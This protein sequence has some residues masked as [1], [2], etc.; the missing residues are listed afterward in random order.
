MQNNEVNQ[1]NEESK[2]FIRR[3]MDWI[4]D[5]EQE[6]GRPPISFMLYLVLV[7]LIG[8]GLYIMLLT[9]SWQTMLIVSV[10]AVIGLIVLWG[11]E[12]LVRKICSRKKN[13]IELNLSNSP[14]FNE[15]LIGQPNQQKNLDGQIIESEKVGNIN[16]IENRQD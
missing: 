6:A 14:N 1:E 4:D 9:C 3:F 5:R 2:F 15:S 16:I 13:V 11:L 7:E 12:K 8:F 10:S